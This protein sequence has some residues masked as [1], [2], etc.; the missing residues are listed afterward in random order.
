M[1]T[2]EALPA[3]HIG[4]R[5]R[6]STHSIFVIATFGL[7]GAFLLGAMLTTNGFVTVQN[8]KA[9]LAS[10]GIVGIVSVGM[11]VI[12]ISGSLFSMAMGITTATMA[13]LYLAVL[14]LGWPLAALLVLL[15]GAIV[16]GLQ[17]WLVGSI[18][19]NPIIITIGAAASIQGVGAWLSDGAGIYA[20]D[21]VSTGFL[22]ASALGMPASVFALIVIALLVAL[23]MQRTPLGT[24]TYFVGENRAAA[25]AAGLPVLRVSVGAFAIAG[26]CAAL[27]GVCVG[28]ANGNANLQANP[29]LTFDAIAAVLVGGSAVTGGHGGVGRTLLGA[30]AIA[31]ISDLLLLRGYDTGVQILVKGLIVLIVVIGMRTLLRDARS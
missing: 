17:G 30:V 5:A 9:I 10:T 28:A 25:R 21:G 14:E 18:G 1:T 15:V 26:F 3:P 29:T 20:P 13:M 19:A 4:T 31:A 2:Q 12:M 16:T 7:I 8:G 22:G 27:A 23:Y 24:Q 11:V 6:P